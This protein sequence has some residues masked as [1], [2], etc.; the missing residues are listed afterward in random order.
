M[1]VRSP[2]VCVLGHVDHGKTTLLDRV[3]GTSVAA[4]EAGA[5]TQ[6]VGAS[7]VPTDVVE[8]RCGELLKKYKFKL[9]I[10]GLLFID[11]PGHEAFT[12][13]RRRGGSVAD[14]AVLVV[15]ISQGFQ[16]QTLEA[17]EILKSYKTPFIVAANKI[18][19]VNGWQAQKEACFG[20]SI[21]KQ[22]AFVAEALDEKVYGLVRK[23]GELGFDSERF[24]RVKD[25]TKQVLIV[26]VSAKTGEGFPE[27]LMFLAGL[28]QKF[29]EKKLSIDVEGPARGTVLEVK[30]V[31]GLGMTI[32]AI[33]YDGCIKA[34]DPIALATLDGPVVTRARALLKPAPLE[35][36]RDPRKKFKAVDKVYAAAGIKIAAPNLE[37]AIA[38]S[39]L[40][41][42]LDEAE[43]KKE[44]AEELGRVRLESPGLGA[45]VKTDALGSLE[46]IVNLFSKAGI[47]I[48]RA[49]VG[50]VTKKDL[51]EA[52]TIRNQNRYLGVIFAF[53]IRTPDD[54]AQEAAD[55]KIKIFESNIIYALEDE[56][57]KW[58]AEEKKREKGEDLAK[59]VYPAKV[60][61]LPGF[62]FRISKPAVVGVEVLAGTLKPKCALMNR[63]GKLVGDIAS[64][65]EKNRPVEKAERGEQVAVA[66]EGA[67]VGR[68]VH[69]KDILF[70]AVPLEQL[71]MLE[72]SFEDKE[73]LNEIKKIRGG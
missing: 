71:E 17:L 1:T 7:F 35:E 48:K 9:T 2:I 13:L 23:L 59:Y 3:R 47:A 29:M 10:P 16:P 57:K 15:D 22:R 46:A 45:I 33:I 43:A 64:L 52:E 34:G 69:E 38:G 41:V 18:D 55:R 51:L 20:E 49:D 72:K 24:D 27:L 40:L 12:N 14:L 31:T 37:R 26:P 67:T 58:Q 44:I 42:A 4:G 5:I 39:P 54:V 30:E 32:D 53:N 63:D 36:I 50:A 73:L 25:L 11:T 66:I 56:Y 62:V 68:Q 61:V 60:R 8:K 19:L 21:A 28:S 6:H 70:T 65:Q